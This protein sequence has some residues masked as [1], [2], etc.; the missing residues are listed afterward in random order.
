MNKWKGRILLV[1]EGSHRDKI[2]FIYKY[3]GRKR[4]GIQVYANTYKNGTRISD[5]D[6]FIEESVIADGKAKYINK[7]EALARML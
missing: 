4:N 3:R 5:F 1:L 6:W 7:K 2:L